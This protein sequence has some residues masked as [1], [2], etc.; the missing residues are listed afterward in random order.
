[1]AITVL[2]SVKSHVGIAGIYY[3]LHYLFYNPFFYSKHL[4]WS[5][6]FYLV[7]LLYFHSLSVWP[8]EILFGLVCWQFSIDLNY[9]E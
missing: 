5:V 2:I 4:S 8:I 9:K 1:M 6:F 3:F 7:I